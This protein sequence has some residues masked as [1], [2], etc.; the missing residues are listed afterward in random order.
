MDQETTTKAV[1]ESV[2]NVQEQLPPQVQMRLREAFSR[3]WAWLPPTVTGVVGIGLG[4]GTTYILMRR[5]LNEVFTQ[6][7]EEIQDIKSVQLELNFERAEKDREFNSAIGDAALVTREL[8]NQGMI[9]LERLQTLSD[10]VEEIPQPEPPEEEKRVQAMDPLERM[11][12]RNTSKLIS[13]GEKAAETIVSNVFDAVSD[14]DW[15]YEAE[16]STRTEEEPYIIHVD[17]FISDEMGWDSQ[18]TITWYEGDKILTDSHDTPIYNPEA[19]VGEIRFGHGSRDPNV[20]YVRNEKLQAEYEILRDE[21]SYEDE[22]LGSRAQN[23]FEVSDLRHAN[24][25]RK[26]RAE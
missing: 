20:V 2:K 12:Q 5:K 24:S 19:M 18:S 11:D 22:V 15:D 1:K 8:K 16:R 23:E 21:G 6:S 3:P 10:Q 4:A 25:P 13:T 17:E 9:L 7:N 14:A 26:F